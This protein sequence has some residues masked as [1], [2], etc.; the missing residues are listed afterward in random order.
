MELSRSCRDKFYL[1]QIVLADELQLNVTRR[2]IHVAT[3]YNG[4]L[5]DFSFLFSR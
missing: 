5:P 3:S 1:L 2:F 4:S